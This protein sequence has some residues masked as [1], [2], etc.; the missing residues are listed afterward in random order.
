[1]WLNWRTGIQFALETWPFAT[2]FYSL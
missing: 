2:S 1:L